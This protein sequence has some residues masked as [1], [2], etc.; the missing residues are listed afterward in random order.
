MYHIYLAGPDV[1][2]TDAVERGREAVRLC[3]SYGYAGLFP[4]DNVITDF[5]NDPQTAHRICEAN[6]EMIKKADIVLANLNPFRGHEPDSGTV[7]ECGFGR[8]LGKQVIVYM[9]DTRSC[10][11]RFSESDIVRRNGEC[12]YKED[13]MI[14]ED[15][16]LP[17]NLMIACTADVVQGDLNAALVHLKQK[18]QAHCG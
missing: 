10:L 12:L 16:K 6:L 14:I 2:Y 13:S 17:L 7:F 4:L 15:F 5:K 8:A 1:F 18:S 3:E 9:Q 11:E